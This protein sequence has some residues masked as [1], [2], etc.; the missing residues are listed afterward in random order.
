MID[1]EEHIIEI[2]K[3]SINYV[4]VGTGQVMIFLHN[5]GG[6]WQT[7][8]KQID[9]FSR[10]Y[11]VIALDWPGFGNSGEPSG[12]ITINLL[13]NVLAEFIDAL[14]LRQF[15][16]VGN[17]IGGSV[18]LKYGLKNPAKVRKLIIINICP[19]D[20]LFSNKLI[21]QAFSAIGSSK[22]WANFIGKILGFLFTKTVLKKKFPAILFAPGFSD[23]DTLYA[24]YQE[25]FKENKQ[26][27]SRVNLL[28]N[29][30]SFT[31]IDIIQDGNMPEHFM[32]LWGEHNQVTSLIPHGYYH[33]ELLK[34]RYFEV[35]KKAGHL[36]AYEQPHILNSLL[37]SFIDE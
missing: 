25:K 13:Y 37:I 1:P 21:A 27:R 23:Q 12:A 24:L 10:K 5:G 9:F 31:A 18:A 35:I 29:V 22:Y 20:R 2:N 32:L 17:C 8:S 16:L 4:D 19:G 3:I 11:R 36:C 33:Q 26:T 28:Y 34:P 7:W 14:Q 15:I 30:G 6:F